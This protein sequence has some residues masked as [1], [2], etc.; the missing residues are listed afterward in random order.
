MDIEHLY[1]IYRDSSSVVTD[2]RK[3][4]EGGLFFALKGA[5]FDGNSF[6]KKAIEEGCSYAVVEDRTIADGEHILYTEN[7]LHTLQEL[8]T[9]H[10]LQWGKTI[11][12]I[13][14]TNGKTTTKELIS[15]VLQRKYNV[16]YTEGN[17]NNQIGVP[18]TLLR[19]KNEHDLAVVEMGANHPEDIKELV[20]IALPNMGLIT[21]I[22]IAHLLGF[23]SFENIKIAKGELYRH[24]EH[25]GG[26]IFSNASDEVLMQVLER[27]KTEK[28][29][30]I[31]YGSHPSSI[32]SGEVLETNGKFSFLLHTAFGEKRVDT[33][34]VGEYNLS[35]VLSAVAVGLNFGVDVQDIVEAIESYTPSNMRSQYKE[36]EHNRLVIDTYN[37]NPTSLKS[38]L[39][40]FLKLEGEKKVVILGDMK[41]LG[42]YSQEEHQKKVKE[43]QEMNLYDAFF[44]G[45]EYSKC[46]VG[47]GKVF[48]STELLCEYLQNNPI[49]N[50]TILIKG[51]RSMELE[52]CVE[53]L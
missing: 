12:S 14:G 18:L 27:G 29:K 10:R 41:E 22:G 20:N 8:A 16:L 7:V 15:K 3:V 21:N 52:K 13:T 42:A 39:H 44:C 47:F 25:K 43:V 2:T 23:G 32:A 4:I 37:A 6:A 31:F 40:S 34:L 50:A 49:E 1:R 24:I 38:A 36:T 17:L 48:I 45:E 11:L 5:N 35:N 51:S 9:Y 46:K 53:F 33:Q 30:Y 26:T 28:V 19:L